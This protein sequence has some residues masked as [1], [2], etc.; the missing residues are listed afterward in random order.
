MLAKHFAAL[1]IVT[2]DYVVPDGFLPL[3]NGSVNFAGVSQHNSVSFD[4]STVA[5]AQVGRLTVAF[6]DGNNGTLTYTVK[7][8]DMPVA[9]TQSKAI[10]R[11]GFA[12]PGTPCQ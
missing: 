5:F 12:V 7:H 3:A 10:T 2:P 8:S 11:Q 6:A 4:P 1:G 9:V